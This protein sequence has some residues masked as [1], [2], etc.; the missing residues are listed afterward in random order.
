[1]KFSL[2]KKAILLILSITL[3]ISIIAI[4]VY[5]MGITRIVEKEYKDRSTEISGLLGFGLDKDRLTNLRDNILDIYNHAENKV[6]SDE[7]QWDSPEFK[8]YIALYESIGETE[9]YKIILEQL[10]AMQ[11]SLHVDCAYIIWLDLPNDCY[12]YLV[13]AAHEEACP[14]G[15]IDPLFMDKS[16]LTDPNIGLPPNIT[17]T[18]EYGW[19]I[20]TGRPIYSD[21]GEIIALGMV[22]ISMNEVVAMQTRYILIVS[23]VLIGLV[24]IVSALS[25]FLFN[26]FIVKPINKLSG[27]ASQYKNNKNVFSQLNIERKDEIGVLAKSMA[28]MEQDINGY[29]SNLEQT[30]NDLITA[31]ENAELMNQAANIDALTK[32]RNKRAYNNDIQHLNE[33]A[34]SFGIVMIDMNGLKAINDTYGH[35]KG[36]IGI[37]TICQNICRIF[38]HSPV[39]R[40][41]GD[42][43]VVILENDDYDERDSLLE[44]L[45]ARFEQLKND[46]SLEP[47]ERVTA[48]IGCATYDPHIDN[49]VE[50]VLQRADALMYENKKEMK[51][52]RKS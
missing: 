20:A 47:W 8:E 51:A 31:R 42:E 44:S 41:G 30:T 2:S 17:N 12:I 24:I 9:D 43:F 21:S 33:N 29:I 52:E 45:R 3:V 11:D 4:V 6:K 28:D 27:A 48:A 35:E 5:A 26:K 36:D 25:I 16:E 19:I 1:M 22:D 37:I 50:S 23:L 40:I 7:Y 15:C 38:K 10:Q 14:I 34:K 39:Y 13:D 46:E 32:V 18:P 49:I